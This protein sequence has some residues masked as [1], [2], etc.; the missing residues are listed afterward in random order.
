MRADFSAPISLIAAQVQKILR[1]RFDQAGLLNWTSRYSEDC[2]STEVGCAVN[3]R[4]ALRNP[5][6]LTM[7]SRSGLIAVT[8]RDSSHGGTESAF[9]LYAEREV[10]GVKKRRH[11]ETQSTYSSRVLDR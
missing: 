11:S 2:G 5:E 4:P 9:G 6:P 8:L 3:Q 1:A 10:V 7:S